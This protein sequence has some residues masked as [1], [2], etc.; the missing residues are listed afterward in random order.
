MSSR[1]QVLSVGLEKRENVKTQLA[2]ITVTKPKNKLSCNEV[3]ALKE[4]RNNSVLNLKKANKGTTVIM[5]TTTTTT[6]QS[7]DGEKH[8]EKG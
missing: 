8:A 5:N 2:E 4:L 3:M 1:V 7:A 6:F